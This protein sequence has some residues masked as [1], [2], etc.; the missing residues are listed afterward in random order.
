[1]A[2][3]TEGGEPAA[4]PS[5]F[6]GLPQDE[7]DVLL[8]TLERRHYPAGAV[9]IAEGDKPNRITIVQNGTAEV[10]V[11]D[12]RGIEH[13]VGWVGP[14]ASVGEMSLFTGQPASGTV[15][16]ATDLE[17]LIMR[18]TEFER[19]AA[20]HP[21][22][23][24]NLGAIL[25][26]RLAR[27]N[28]LAAGDTT[29]HLGMLIDRGG[30]PE[31]A[32]AVAASIAWHTQTATLLIVLGDDPHE[33]LARLASERASPL[34]PRAHLL[35]VPSF[36]ALRER[37]LTGRIDDLFATYPQILLLTRDGSTPEVETTR[38]LEL[39]DA[40]G[41]AVDGAIVI[42]GWSAASANTARAG[43]GLVDVPP[44][45]RQDLE[46]L[47]T[48]LLPTSTPA[49]RAIGSVGRELAGLKVGLV[50]G[51]GSLKGYAHFGALHALERL[52]I[53]IDLVVGTSVGALAA[54]THAVGMTPAE[55]IAV[56]DRAGPSIFRPR[57][58]TKSLLTNRPLARFFR[59]EIGEAR[60]ED[61]PVPLAVVAADLET[62]REVVFRRGLIWLSLL[63]SMSIPGIFPAVRVGGY[64]VADGGILNPV[65]S[66]VAAGMGADVVVAV[67]LSAGTPPLEAEAEAVESAGRVPSTLG[68]LLRSVDIMYS[69]LAS[70]LTE[71]T[72]ITIT[73]ELPE[74]PGANLRNFTRGGGYVQAGADAV[75]AALPRLRVALPWLTP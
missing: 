21:Q 44:L 9:V 17:V 23:Y 12:R 24:R 67:K 27:T 49:G 7:L 59:D 33:D 26:E 4:A 71:T 52:G 60:I 29:G 74:L 47:R 30:P 39:T 22:V 64:T 65:P 69:R 75:H 18:E 68:V 28:R 56:F 36:D 50:L 25:A 38:V 66:T 70:D 63:A 6:D 10:F 19:L 8:G 51:A 20:R 54:G 3:A 57:I 1:M 5:L 34:E 72:M 14:G 58:S 62:Q 15:R 73:P 46:A 48:G 45:E 16:A 53:P 11:S 2:R 41:A 35:A 61:M 13:R 31:L 42:R 37:S 43:S 32:W 55:A 40:N